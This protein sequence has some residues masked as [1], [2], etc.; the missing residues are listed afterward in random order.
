MKNCLIGHDSD[1]LLGTIIIGILVVMVVT[2][3][4]VYGG[5]LIGGFFSLRNYGASFKHNVY[6]SNRSVKTAA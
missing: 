1:S 4:I 3:I 2:A 6:D 5:A